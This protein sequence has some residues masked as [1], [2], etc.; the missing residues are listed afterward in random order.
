MASVVKGFSLLGVDGYVVE[1]ETKTIDSQPMISIVGL[2]DTAIKE[3][4]ERLE[5]VL[6][7]GDYHF[8]KMK[9]VI[10]L[11]PS[12]LKKAGTHFD[13][14]MAV[15]LLMESGQI[16]PKEIQKY[17]FIGEL[18]L[19]AKLRS[20]VGVLPMVMAAKESG[21]KNIIVSKENIQE[22]SL[23]QGM[24]IFGFSALKEVADFLEGKKEYE[25]PLELTPKHQ[26]QHLYGLDFNEVQGQDAMIEYIVVAAA[27]GH[28]LLM[29]GAPGC[30]KSMIAKR[31][32]TVLPSMMEA[33]SLEVTKIYS[34]AGLLRKRGYLIEDRPFRAP[35]HNA[36]TN[37]LIGGGNN[38]LPGEISLS[39]NG[40]LFLD[41]IAE[42]NKKTLEALRQP[43]EDRRVTISRVRYTNTYPANFMLV[44]A[45]NPCPCGHYGSDRCQCSDYEV[46]KYRQKISGPILDRMDIQKYVQP[47]D[48]LQL[49]EH[50]S[51]R[52]SAELR[53]RVEFA[54]DIQKT[55]YASMEAINCNAQMTPSLIKE[56]CELEADGTKLLRLAYDRF[57]Y[58]ARTF[59]KFLKVGRTFADMEGSEKIRKKDIAAALMARDLDKEQAGMLVL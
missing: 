34:V 50:T 15:G 2:G 5:A 43:M 46:I 14:A 51:G 58:S 56:Y 52:S 3:A 18:S 24:N 53:E 16:R 57:Q 17:G 36:S 48:F 6:N 29:I 27:G 49:S 47:V 23:V 1:V 30:G 25:I 37:S 7:H 28:N 31:I 13:L 39:H 4:K 22:A 19:N 35:H 42:F 59:H 44:A 20:C 32:P 26:E 55:R 12:D 9:I 21:I 11:A 54:R 40:V 38:A 45:M 8:P 10:N 33:E 41:E